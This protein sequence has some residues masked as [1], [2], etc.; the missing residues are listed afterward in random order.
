VQ[1]EDFYTVE[2]TARALKLTPER[3]QQIFRDGELEGLV[4]QEGGTSGWKIPVQVIHGR[5]RPPPPIERSQSS[6]TG[7]ENSRSGSED[8]SGSEDTYAEEEPGP[9]L[10]QPQHDEDAAENSRE[11][12][13]PS[14]HH[15]SVKED[16]RSSQTGV[17]ARLLETKDE[18]IADL[19]DRVAFLERQLEGRTE[20]IRR[21]DHILAALTERIPPAIKAPDHEKPLSAPE[22]TVEEPTRTPS[23][24]TAGPQTGSVRSQRRRAL[25]RWVFG[26]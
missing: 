22:S 13:S 23:L 17:D 25:W 8:I 9:T 3:I 4:M 19:R 5:N 16:T 26:R 20:E 7:L 12:S 1:G 6:T 15:G 10:A 18:V 21:R 24:G 2:E 14:P 11:P